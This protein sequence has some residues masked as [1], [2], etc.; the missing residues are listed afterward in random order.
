MRPNPT[1]FHSTVTLTD[2]LCGKRVSPIPSMVGM[3]RLPV[4]GDGIWTKMLY[5]Y[6]SRGFKE[7]CNV[8]LLYFHL[9]NRISMS[10]ER[11][12][13]QPGVEWIKWRA[14][15]QLT[16][17]GQVAQARRK[18]VLLKATETLRGCLLL[19]QLSK[20]WLILKTAFLTC[21]PTNWLNFLVSACSVDIIC[22]LKQNSCFIAPVSPL[23]KLS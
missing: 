12:C 1:G 20:S 11:L 23:V 16:H 21:E 22:S 6:P 7:H 17:E 19:Q 9:C 2:I 15:E 13:L 10:R 3:A 4:K 18:P 5:L 14:E 8:Q